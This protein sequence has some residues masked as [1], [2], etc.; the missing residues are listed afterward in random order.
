[1]KVG[2]WSYYESLNYNNY[3]LLNK[4]SSI[5]EDLLKPFN[6]LYNEGKRQ[7]IIFATL[8][9]ITSYDEINT[10]IFLDF[11]NV[12][13]K[14]VQKAFKA[15]KN[16]MLV[17]FESELIKP[18]N[19]DINNHKYFSKIFTWNDSWVDNKK[20][21]KFNF[22][23]DI[24]YTIN[25]DISKKEKLCTMIAGNKLSKRPLELYSKRVE[26]IRWFEKNNIEDFDLYGVGWDEFTS[27]NRY[28]RFIVKKLRLS[29]IL[30]SKF[31]RY[32]GKIQTKRDVLMKYKFS[33]CYENA[34]DIS[35][36]ITE[37]I[38]DC[39]LASC[40][41]IYWGA[42]NITEHIPD[43]CF[44]DKR[45]FKSYDELYRYIKNMSDVE[46]TDYLL[47]IDKFLNS[48]KAYQ[49]SSDFFS[50]TIIDN[51]LDVKIG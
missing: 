17:I 13:N 12:K 34:K 20:Y 50:K 27:S 36:Y 47:N 42:N 7:N 6:D 49:F 31:P 4:N 25:K 3:M 39:F 22:A 45:N 35:G 14:F 29:K 23:C 30:S 24:P 41:P 16:M 21:F 5:G 43:N 10:V 40:V 9:T 26:A 37:K 46:Y 48:K 44:I 19:W 32:K 1:M 33:I 38:F 11:P 15:K 51:I 8:D 2:I 28:L 18:N